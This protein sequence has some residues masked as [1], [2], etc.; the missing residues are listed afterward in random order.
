MIVGTLLLVMDND[1]YY[2]PPMARQTLR[3]V[4]GVQ[5]SNSVGTF[6]LVVT[7]EHRNRDDTGWGSAGAFTPITGSGFWQVDLSGLKEM[8]RYKYAFTSGNPT[9]GLYVIPAQPQWLND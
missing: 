5:T 4:F 3:G 8:V 2:G 6:Q 9:D 1:P 7:V